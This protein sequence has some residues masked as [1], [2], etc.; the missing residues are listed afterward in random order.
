M[1]RIVLFKNNL[2]VND[3]P[4]LYN[5]SRNG[6]ILPVYIHDTHNTK[7]TIGSAS[8]Y[9]LHN[10]LKSLNT[11]LSNRIHFFRGDSISILDVLIARYSIKSVYIENPY[12]NDDLEIY[13][14]LHYHLKKIGVELRN[15]N[16]SLL[17][18]P[19]SILK[20]DNTPYKVFTPFYRKGCLQFTEPDR[21]VGSPGP[22]NFLETK[23]LTQLS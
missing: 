22:M 4:V 14:K 23:N 5:A 20:K 8:K 16:C 7:K 18:E 1:N 3:N 2:R 21:P 11:N 9:W 10:A 13:E 6:K 15:Y 17:W 19:S 12:T